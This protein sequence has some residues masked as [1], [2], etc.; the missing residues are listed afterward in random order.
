MIKTYNRINSIAGWLVFLVAAIVYCLTIEPTASFWDCGEYIAC[1]YGLEVGHPPGAPLFLL[2]ARCFGMLGGPENAAM[3]INV[4]SALCSAFTIL[5]LFWTITRLARKLVLKTENDYTLPHIVAVIAAG[6]IG[7]LGF[8]FTDSFWFSAVEGEVYAMSSL[9]TAAVFW[10]MLRWEEVADEPHADRWL[11]LIAYLI[12]LSIGVHLLNLLT[13]PALV[14]TWYFRKNKKITRKGLLLALLASVLLL[15]LV[16]NGIIPGIVKLAAKTELLFVNDFGLPFDSGTVFYFTV[17]LGGL[18][19][20]IW[21]THRRKK[22]GWNIA[23]LSFGMLLIGYSSFFVLII[24]SQAGTPI[25]ENAPTNAISLLSYLNREQYGDWP[26]LYG[27]YYNTP[28]DPQEPYTDGEPLYVRDEKSGTYIISD[29]RKGSKYNYDSRFCTVFPRMWSQ[30]GSHAGAYKDWAEIKGR[31]VEVDLRGGGK[32]TISL[33]TFGENLSFFARY[34]VG[35]MYLRYFGWNFMGRQNDR[36]GYGSVLN[37]WTVSGLPFIDNRFLHDHDSL[38]TALRNNKAHNVYYGLPFIL[39]LLGFFWLLKNSRR[40]TLV[41]TLL[42]LCT[43]FAIVLYL[44]QTP[45][46]PRERD[47]AYA[48]SFYAFAIWMGLGVLWIHDRLKKFSKGF[49]PVAG[50]TAV[51]AIVPLLLA[52]QN[53]DDHD[54]SDR[55][56]ARDFAWN[57]LQSCAPNAILFTYADNDTFPLWYLQEVE[58]VRR[59]VRVICLSLFGSDWHIDQMQRKQYDSERLPFTLKHEQYREGT[60]DFIF[61]ETENGKLIDAR[62]AVEFIRSDD[63]KNKLQDASN[64]WQSYVPGRN[65]ILPV[66]KSEIIRAKM[67]PAEW[68][69]F[70]PDTFSWTLRGNYMMKDQMMI[71]DLVAHNDW[72]RPIYF[73]AGMPRSAYGGFDD[74]LQLEGLA[75]R[76]VPVDK[77]T[78]FPDNPAAIMMNTAVMYKN[79]KDKFRFGGC[80]NPDVYQDESVERFFTEPIRTALANLS[81]GLVTEKQYA[82][83]AEIA[84]LSAAK[85]PVENTPPNN[86]VYNLIDPLYKGGKIKE[87]EELSRKLFADYEEQCRFYFKLSSLGN[88]ITRQST[89][90]MQQLHWQAKENGRT[91]L[92][93]EFETRMQEFGIPVYVPLP[94]STAVPDSMGDSMNR[95]K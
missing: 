20:G 11:I 71:L 23:L 83:A 74:H 48:G 2:V 55:T 57:M 39:G 4:M 51:S 16:Q 26:L 24:R 34:Q 44:N 61:V 65:M 30:N 45:Y 81:S 80:E 14:F 33:P 68:E 28:L 54:R 52:V 73:A 27:Q 21:F 75:Y 58:G 36:L 60:R 59:D 17:L 84:T 37:G 63:Q 47:Y 94:D 66:N 13:I 22:A 69:K 95:P 35:F 70:I 15:G 10:A 89:D 7:A 42:F 12:G 85:I 82:K 1:A 19:Y 32:D 86:D 88:D 78:I 41:V 87:A 90:L 50:A 40:D 31:T 77:K 6:A 18:V 3:M 38:P 9:F 49:I 92:A 5:F 43:G 62:A 25:N 56:V 64:R 72:K 67:V 91:A 93:N 79:V 76:L 53:W 29:D 8:T 46:Q